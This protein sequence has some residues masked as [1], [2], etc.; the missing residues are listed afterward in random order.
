MHAAARLLYM[1]YR[2]ES[3]TIDTIDNIYLRS[4]GIYYLCRNLDIMQICQVRSFVMAD[5]H[6]SLLS[7][8]SDRLFESSDATLLPGLAVLGQDFSCRH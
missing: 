6:G 8:R 3:G 2:Y 4:E 7:L 1:F 5:A